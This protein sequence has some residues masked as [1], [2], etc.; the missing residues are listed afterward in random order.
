M[1]TNQTNANNVKNNMFFQWSFHS[2]LSVHL[3]SEWKKLILNNEDFSNYRI[4]AA[5]STHKNLGQLRSQEFLILLKCF[6]TCRKTENRHR[7]SQGHRSWRLNHC[8]TFQYTHL[9]F[10]CFGIFKST[11]S[12]STLIL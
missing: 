5:Y 9:I 3:M 8:L 12:Y 6:F 7:L 4:I 2:P 1:S 11:L 10:I